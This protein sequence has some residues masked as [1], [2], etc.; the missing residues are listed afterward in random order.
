MISLHA[1]FR[2]R[3]LL[4]WSE[5]APPESADAAALRLAE[6]LLEIGLR[7]A[8]E[9]FVSAPVWLPTV[10]KT[11]VPSSALI[12]D[13]PAAKNVRIAPWTVVAAA[14][15]APDALDLLCWC[16][17]KELAAPGVVVG[18]DTA[19]W[20]AAMQFAGALVARQQFL[21]GLVREEDGYHARWR[22]VCTGRD[23]ERLHALAAAMP[24]AARAF[25]PEV[26]A[27]HVLGG[28]L[29]S[30][31][32]ALARAG[33]RPGNTGVLHDRWIAAL[34]SFDGKLT[35]TEEE[36][37][38]LARQLNDWRRPI[39]VVANA[40]FRLCFRLEEPFDGAG[41][42]QVRYL[43]QSRKDPSLQVP[44]EAVWQAKG[45]KPALPRSLTESGFQ[46]REHM[47]L[48]LG[49]ASG[50][51]PRIEE[52][53]K[54]AAPGGYELDAI[55]AHDF[56]T[57][58]AIAL[59]EAGFGVMLPAW[60]TRKGTKARLTAGARVKSAFVSNSGLSLNALLDFQWEISI[61]GEKI[62]LAELRAL[63]ALK[64][65]LVK[66]RGQW[67]HVNAQEIQAALDFW[68]K[69][70]AGQM[71]AREAVR[72]ALGA[73]T[74]PGP[75]EF[76][77]VT[78]EGW[79][80]DLIQQLEGRTA[81]EEIA[82]PDGLRATLRPYQV[83]GYSWLAFV[84]RWGLGACL[85]DDMGLGKTIQ[86]LSLIQRDRREGTDRPVLLICPTSVVG[87]WQKEAARFTPELPVMVHHG[88]DRAKGQTFSKR[89]S[90]Q[91]IVLSSYALLHRDFDHLKDVSWAGVV[92]DEAQNIKNPETKQAAA[93]RATRCRLPHRADG[94]AGREQCGGSVVDPRVFES[95]LVGDAR[96]VQAQLLPAH[97][98]RRRSGGGSPAE[99][100]HRPVHSA[101][102]ENG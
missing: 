15:D 35:G 102:A 21:P 57:A 81:F 36:L 96:G 1:G 88:L 67:V 37:H 24:P 47:L 19:F 99:E 8:L 11:P 10:R 40:P 64:A 65:P 91:A 6:I 55:G 27:I 69:K 46:P 48:S 93:A 34:T 83:R 60:W 41:E 90:Q 5:S 45:A 82:P 75:L 70:G 31:A 17:S 61:G 30:I 80:G 29:D 13:I 58:K 25:T 2:G 66:F 50:V 74:L 52:S 39:A 49:Q 12:G 44:A 33:L 76:G 94:N 97:P 3:Q 63:A 87:N 77:G 54:S 68:K 84:K 72:M 14:L 62:T 79:I 89:A 95:G 73:A 18:P 51:C 26:P 9:S 22:A 56:L 38:L 98:E 32:D 92:L 28:F 86:T 42:W 23:D 20:V 85:A 78:A 43:L 71:T 101:A 100:N 59:E 53:L 7:P 4:L 16:A